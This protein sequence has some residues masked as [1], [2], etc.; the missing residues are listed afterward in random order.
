MDCSCP[1]PVRLLFA[2]HSRARGPANSA[3]MRSKPPAALFG[4]GS[5][6]RARDAPQP[7][8]SALPA[9]VRQQAGD[10]GDRPLCVQQQDQ[11]LL[12]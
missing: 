4:K 3:S 5:A 12:S 8:A 7:S 10:R 9:I 1:R 2:A 6:R 11:E